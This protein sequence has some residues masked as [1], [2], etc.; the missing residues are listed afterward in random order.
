LKE[1]KEWRPILTI[2]MNT[3]YNEDNLETTARLP[4][5]SVDLIVTDPP[6][7]YGFMG[8]HWDRCVPDVDIWKGCYKV[9][10]PG[11]FMFVMSAP[12]QDVLSRMIVNI[13]DA[14]FKIDFTSLYWAYASGFPKAQNMSKAIDK[15]LG[16][17]R[18]STG[19]GKCGKTAMMG[20]LYGAQTNV[21]E[22]DITAPASPESHHFDGWYS[23]YQPKPALEIILVAMKP[24]TQKTYVDQALKSI[25]DDSQGSGCVNFDACRVPTAENLMGGAYQNSS[26]TVGSNQGKRE[27][28][29]KSSFKQPAGRFPANLIVSDNVLDDG[30]IRES[31]SGKCISGGAAGLGGA[32]KGHVFENPHDDSGQ[33]SRYFNLDAWYDKLNIK[34][35]PKRVQKTFPVLIVPKPSK[36]EK[37]AGTDGINNHPTVKPIKLISYLITLA[38]RPGQLVYDPFG[39]SGTTP[40]AAEKLSRK[41]IMSEIEAASCEIA[42][43]RI[44]E[45]TKQG[46][47]F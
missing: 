5:N 15:R 35:L 45:A 36:A 24:I 34:K 33:F 26:G 18:E 28:Q 21:G 30:I 16:M 10:K 40:V 42:Q 23:G 12:R 8:K 27:V 6:Y 47:L 7:G 13:E 9:L 1:N 19:K 44:N 4:E 37:N 25:N 20:G 46:R 3:I 2:E 31:T 17:E 41:W 32:I 43:A 22:Y 39:G 14:G 11:A 29:S 38:S